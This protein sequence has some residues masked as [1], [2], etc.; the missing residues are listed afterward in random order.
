MLYNVTTIMTPVAVL[1][2]IVILIVQVVKFNAVADRDCT[3][4][5]RFDADHCKQ[6]RLD[7]VRRSSST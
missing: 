5:G 7:N 4:S 2:A 6:L 3:P 1:L